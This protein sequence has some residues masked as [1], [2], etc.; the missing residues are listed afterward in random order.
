M[1]TMNWM[2][3]RHWILIKRIESYQSIN[4]RI[5]IFMHKIL[6]FTKNRINISG[7]AEASKIHNHLLHFF[8][9]LRKWKSFANNF[10]FPRCQNSD[11]NQFSFWVIIGFLDWRFARPFERNGLMFTTFFMAVGGKAWKS[12][13]S[14]FK[15]TALRCFKNRPFSFNIDVL[16]ILDIFSL[17]PNAM[18][19]HYWIKY[20]K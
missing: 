4:W 16:N 8:N 19:L 20:L 13:N 3:W 18:C 11:F 5:S 10:F 9:K 6:P 17:T 15:L 12:I 14:R 7:K 2:S 1:S